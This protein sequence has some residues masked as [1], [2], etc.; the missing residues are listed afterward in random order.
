MSRIAW[1]IALKDLR[2][3]CREPMAVFWAVAFPVLF[4]VFFGKVLE[5]ALERQLHRV[6]VVVVDT[7]GSE[8][9]RVFGR[10]LAVSEALAVQVGTPDSGVQ[11]VRRA[12]AAAYLVIPPGFGLAAATGQPLPELTL[13]VDPAKQAEKAMLQA[14]LTEALHRMQ[15]AVRGE[16]AAAPGFRVEAVSGG[17]APLD[18]IA[19]VFPAAVLWGLIGCAATFSVGMVSERTRGTLHR[20]L[21]AP[22]GPGTILG[23]KALACFLACLV[24]G[25][26]LFAVALIGL[27]VP[28]VSP[29]LALLALISVAACF[30]G[31]TVL[32]SVLGRTEQAVAGSTWSALIVMTMLGGGM[33]PLSFFPD[34]LRPF[35]DLS[36]VKWAILGL[37]G[38]MWRGFSLWEML[39]P[40]GLLLGMGLVAFGAGVVQL[41]RSAAMA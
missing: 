31:L 28:L 8:V 24:D 21:S 5:V 4:A 3:L 12:D 30:T 37:E 27:G 15:R 16:A 41:R 6:P 17:T 10:R 2:L 20:L 32:L 38:A 36:P 11:A 22:I 25:A 33:V 34:W 19:L 26:L 18:G 13:G 35:S 39:L 29:G 40:C 14:L 7:D 1:W 23:G 9:S